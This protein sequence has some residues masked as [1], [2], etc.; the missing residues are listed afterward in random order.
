MAVGH[1][2]DSTL[3]LLM[4]DPAGSLDIVDR[5]LE[6][7]GIDA[8]IAVDTTIRL[9]PHANSDRTRRLASR[10]LEIILPRN[11]GT[12][13]D[14]SLDELL[15]TMGSSLNGSQAIRVGLKRGLSAEVVAANLSAFN[16]SP[17]AVR[18]R[19]MLAIEDLAVMIVARGRIDYPEHAVSD[20][21]S[22]LWDSSVVDH[23]AF[24][25]SSVT[26]LPFLLRSLCEPASPLIASAFPSVYRALKKANDA[27]DLFKFFLF[28]DWDKRKI[29][30][31][32]LVEALMRSNWRATDI[33]LAAARAGDPRRI[34]RCI[35]EQDNGARMVADIEGNL[36]SIPGPWRGQVSDALQHLRSGRSLVDHSDI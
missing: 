19:I 29:A 28:A 16:R 15:R 1:Q 5:L 14:A 2:R 4:R 18:H 6:D 11:T 13:R 24:V 3:Q 35:A 10:A 30:R 12:G 26:L 8:S 7:E 25:R 22:L 17:P 9:L 32:E 36:S 20:A 23:Q 34:L 33:A 27:P 31:R 21:A